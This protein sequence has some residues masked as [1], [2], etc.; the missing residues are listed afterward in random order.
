[1]TAT[2]PA[3]YKEEG[4][5]IIDEL[6]ISCFITKPLE[7]EEIAGKIRAILSQR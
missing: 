7:N 4:S 5:D 1:L 6:G 3:Y 2:D